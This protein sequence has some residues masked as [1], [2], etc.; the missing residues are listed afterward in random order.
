MTDPTIRDAEPSTPTPSS[1]PRPRGP[2]LLAVA[3][4]VQPLLIGVNAIFHPDID[5]TGAGILAGAEEGPTR[6]YVVHLLAALG[7]VLGAPAAFGLRRLIRERRVLCDTALVA[8]VVA[9]V[10]LSLAFMAEASALRLAASADISAAAALSLAEAYT[11]TPEFYAVPSGVLASV[12]A[13][14][15]FAI[16]LLRERRVPRWQPA[17]LV[18]GWLLSLAAMPG[19]LLGPLAFGVIAVASFGLARR[20]ADPLT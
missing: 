1:G 9:S 11:S 3:V 20:I 7:A 16:A 6:W 13:P 2:L 5:V 14:V 18:V 19:T 4:A 15:L 17:A 10:V 12:V 8:A